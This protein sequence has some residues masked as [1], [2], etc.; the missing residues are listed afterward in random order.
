MPD[1]M[2]HADS[3]RLYLTGA[4]SD[5]AAQANA[6]ASLGGFRSSSEITHLA[7]AVTSPISNITIG[8]VSGANGT[9]TG[10]L[11]A[12]GA[13]TLTWSAPGGSA[14]AAQ[15]IANGETKILEAN[16]APEKFVRVTRTSAT[17]LGGTATVTLTNEFNNV[18][19]F[20]NVSSA[21]AAAGDLEYRAIMARNVS[22]TGVKN[23]KAY[24]GTLG[25]QLVSGAAQLSASG[26]G[27]VGPASGAFTDWPSSGY[28]RIE[29]SAN[30]LKE[31]VYYSSRT[32]SALTVPA[33]GRGRLGT[34][35]QA[36]ASTDKIYPVPG[37]R[38][39]RETPASNAIQT[40]ANEST[41]PTGITWS[42][43][44]TADTGVSIG[45]LAAGALHGLWIER[46]VVAG[47]TAEAQVINK[48]SWSFDAA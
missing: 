15:T 42:T 29:S 3:L 25:T 38:I 43:G 28:C 48:I 34:S 23:V 41:P 44:I 46:A 36:G 14:G 12:T 27:S 22:A 4:A 30:A 1:Q 35:A 17:A 16:G 47:A 2:T 6:D 13:D 9:G 31:I 19:G 33:G 45:D 10:T 24:V 37:I 32:N 11:T 5:G 7:S 21:E 18:I 39:G 26:A 8:F 40:V 20:D